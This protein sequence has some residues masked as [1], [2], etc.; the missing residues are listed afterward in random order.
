VAQIVR[1]A[2]PSIQRQQDRLFAT[3]ELSEEPK[4]AWIARF[5]ERADFSIFRYVQS[6]IFRG[7][8][9]RIDLPR[10]QDLEELTKAVDRFIEGANLDTK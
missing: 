7:K 6:A 2:E 5:R 8:E 10:E 1:T 9:I 3:F 4:R